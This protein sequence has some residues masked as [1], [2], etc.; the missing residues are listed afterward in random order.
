LAAEAMIRTQPYYAAVAFTRVIDL[1]A[2]EFDLSP[3]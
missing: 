1:V 2:G 3:G